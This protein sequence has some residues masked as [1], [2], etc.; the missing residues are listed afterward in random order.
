[1]VCDFLCDWSGSPKRV[2]SQ[3]RNARISQVG[4]PC[5]LEQRHMYRRRQ[6]TGLLSE[7]WTGTHACMQACMHVC[8][9]AGKRGD[10]RGRRRARA[11]ASY[12]EEGELGAPGVS[13]IITTPCP[14]HPPTCCD[15]CLVHELTLQTPQGGELRVALAVSATLSQKWPGGGMCVQQDCW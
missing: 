12:V 11:V 10:R 4:V 9:Q 8:M 1:M 5:L 6:A 14:T 7:E 2:S 3:V 13:T 15:G